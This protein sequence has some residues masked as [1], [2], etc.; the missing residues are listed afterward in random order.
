MMTA[1]RF[2]RTVILVAAPMCEPTPPAGDVTFEWPPCSN[3]PAHAACKYVDAK[4]GSTI[5]VDAL[6][7]PVFGVT[8]VA[9]CEVSK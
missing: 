2:A 5:C 9:D 3:V 8:C 7:M 4:T 1:A 6:H